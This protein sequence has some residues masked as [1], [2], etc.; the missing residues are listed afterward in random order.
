MRRVELAATREAT[1][2]EDATTMSALLSTVVL[3]GSLLGGVPVGL[4]ASSPADDTSGQVGVSSSGVVSR[5]ADGSIRYHTFDVAGWHVTNLGGVISSAPATG[6]Y[7]GNTVVVGSNGGIVFANELATG[8]WS[9]WAAIAQGSDP[10]VAAFHDEFHIVYKG[11][12][13]N[14]MD[15]WLTPT[16]THTQNLG[17]LASGS[18]AVAV[19]GEGLHIVA[20]NGGIVFHKWFF[21]T[22]FGWYDWTPVSTGSSPTAIAIDATFYVA[23][24]AWNGNVILA[25]YEPAAW[26]HLNLGGI[27]VGAPMLTFAA[28]KYHLLGAN[29]GWVF[30]RTALPGGAWTDWAPLTAGRDPVSPYDLEF[31]AK[32]VYKIYSRVGV[33]GVLYTL[34]FYGT[35]STV[36]LP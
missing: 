26:H 15:T 32:L 30:E 33:D 17:G 28:G 35:T 5:A 12:A 14:V 31:G 22:N 25:W 9:G 23:S 21:A 13:G 36:L 7:A 4:P 10:V 16:G 24:R 20:A 18:L 1:W 8:T 19:V 27:I 2:E 29:V 6:I 3:F 34:F 11:P